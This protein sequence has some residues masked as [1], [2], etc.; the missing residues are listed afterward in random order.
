MPS[1]DELRKRLDAAGLGP[2]ADRLIELGVPAVRLR[3]VGDSAG[4]EP[5]HRATA[6]VVTG[7]EPPA[8]AV[9]GAASLDGGHRLALLADG[10]VVA[11]GQ[12]GCGQLGDGSRAAADAPVAVI[13]LDDVVAIAAGGAHSLA[14][15]ADGSVMG[16]GDNE[17]AQAGGRSSGHRLRP[18]RVTGLDGGVRA[19]AAGD[20]DSL[21]L[22]DDGSVVWWGLYAQGERLGAIPDAP[23]AMPGLHAITCVS[24]G[25]S[26][27]LALQ[28]DGSVLAWAT[29]TRP[30]P[31]PVRGLDQP[32]IA[33]VAGATHSLALM[34][35]GSVMGWG[36]NL[37]G[38]LGHGVRSTTETEPV[39]AKL[40]G[41]A[42]A[43]AAGR[44]CSFALLRDGS[45]AAWGVNF[46]GALGDG[47]TAP[48][49][50]P[51]AVHGLDRPARAITVRAAVLD[52]GSLRRWGGT[53]R[54]AAAARSEIGVG[55][56][57]LGGLPDLPADSTW[58]QRE[59]R[60]M[61]FLAQVDLAEVAPHAEPDEGLPAAGL[62]SLFVD[63]HELPEP[64][65][66]E[67][68][69]TTPGV[70]LAR[71]EAPVE[72]AGYDRLAPVR[73]VPKREMSWLPAQ[74][75][76][77]YLIGLQW[78]QISEYEEALDDWDERPIHR[79]LG[80]PTLL[81]PP[82]PRDADFELRLLL[83]VDYDDA[84]GWMWGDVGCLHVWIR[85][86]DLAAGRFDRAVLEAQSA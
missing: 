35:D 80:H 59:G 12:N 9:A 51:V 86:D 48:R 45:V 84:A 62:L 81:Q 31:A 16:W 24:S 58:P 38:E 74:S 36:S 34:Q 64:G 39:R 85:R 20:R 77:L 13:D 42:V 6:E 17:C 33:V 4:Q 25:G 69:F 65:S 53:P 67:L 15:R 2:H 32:A 30:A 7:V 18:A 83:Q 70:A 60:P 47:T 68:R 43:I 66:W 29:M 52:D 23:F 46:E 61:V 63:G 28:Q 26:Q 50:S 3:S 75:N 76:V 1:A 79:M 41:P 56:S 72:L 21:A 37:G 71:L 44:S 8:A 78:P 57:R 11:W 14:L 19:I 82:D 40:A 54:R 10:H 27:A 73:L 5:A 22:L 49:A 55:L